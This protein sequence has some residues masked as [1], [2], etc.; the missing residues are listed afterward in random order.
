MPR[1][2]TETIN[3]YALG[4]IVD[5]YL[6]PKLPKPES[7]KNV[8]LFMKHIYDMNKATDYT[9]DLLR[10]ER[11]SPHVDACQKALDLDT[12]RF[13]YCN[14][15]FN[16]IT[17]LVNHT[18][19]EY[20]PPTYLLNLIKQYEECLDRAIASIHLHEKKFTIEEYNHYI[21]LYN[22]NLTMLSNWIYFIT[23]KTSD[24]ELE[25]SDVKPEIS[26]NTPLFIICYKTLKTYY[27]IL[28]LSRI[29]YFSILF[30][31]YLSAIDYVKPHFISFASYAFIKKNLDSAL[32]LAKMDIKIFHELIE[33]LRNLKYYKSDDAPVMYFR[34]KKH[35]YR[36]IIYLKTYYKLKTKHNQEF[37]D[38]GLLV[39]KDLNLNNFVSIVHDRESKKYFPR[40]FGKAANFQEYKLERRIEDLESYTKYMADLES[41]LKYKENNNVPLSNTES[42]MISLFTQ[43]V[44]SQNQ[45]L[46]KGK[47]PVSTI[48][49]DQY[50]KDDN[51]MSND[52]QDN[53][54]ENEDK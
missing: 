26:D 17:D 23:Q 38:K 44:V 21:S 30:K 24:T 36:F 46:L 43:V 9:M 47:L 18:E 49:D 16:D 22:S 5:S 45:A 25:T 39:Q 10:K 12:F 6:L 51:E 50:N 40:F 1:R 32:D 7:E 15:P 33:A 29:L 42:A 19:Y 2:I 13:Y 53:E 37:T 14:L 8:I 52:N 34:N 31:K 54:N 27:P 20:E 41:H 4:Q 3:I 35:L 11:P 28:K 48:K